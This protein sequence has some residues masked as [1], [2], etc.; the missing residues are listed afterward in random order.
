MRTRLFVFLF[1]I[2]S[3]ILLAQEPVGVGQWRYHIPYKRSVAVE[4]IGDEIF[5]ANRY[6]IFSYEK[7]TGYISYY[8]KRDYLSDVGI[9][10]LEYHE[11]SKSLFIAY[12]S[13]NLDVLKNDKINNFNDIQ[14]SN[15]VSSKKINNVYFKDNEAYLLCPFGIIVFNIDHSEFRETYSIRSDLD[16]DPYD[17]LYDDGVFYVVSDQG[18]FSVL[19]QDLL[20]NSKIEWE[21]V[22]G[23]LP[24]GSYN[25]IHKFH[26][27]IFVNLN[28][29]DDPD[30]MYS[31]NNGTWSKLE[32]FEYFDN[33]KHIDTKLGEMIVTH[34]YGCT[35]H[36]ETFATQGALFEYGEGIGMYTERAKY[37]DEGNVWVADKSLGLGSSL[38]KYILPNGPDNE[39]AFSITASNNRL[40]VATGNRAFSN[41]NNYFHEGMIHIFE[42]EEWKSLNRFDMPE[43]EAVFDILKIVDDP[44]DSKRIYASSLGGGIIEIYDNNFSNLYTD[45]NSSL[46]EED[47][48]N[49]WQYVG[50]SSIDVDASGNLWAVNTRSNRG[51]HVKTPEGEWYGYSIP[52]LSNLLHLRDIKISSSGLKWIQ[53]LDGNNPGLFVYDDNGTVENQADDSKRM[54]VVGEGLGNL[55]SNRV[56]AMEEDHDGHMWVGTTQGLVVF[57]NPQDIINNLQDAQQVTTTSSE[58][59]TE[60]VLDGVGINAI[61]IDGANRKWIGTESNGVY[62]LSADGSEEIYHFDIENSPLLSNYIQSINVHPTSGEVFVSTELGIVSFRGDATEGTNDYDL[63]YVFPNPVK[64]SY[65]GVISITGLINS[66]QVKITDIAGNVVFETT[67]Q[68]GQASWYGRDYSGK[69]VN[70]GVYLIYCYAPDGGSR[71]A[72]KVIL[73]N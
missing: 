16:I 35:T 60:Y 2:T 5:C 44:T 29:K 4:T 7:S 43:L 32:N 31:W 73:I 67:S 70:T 23:N 55:P 6:S 63:A 50:V 8:D 33:N 22:T 36:N 62:L 57:Y 3:S 14:R 66:S 39:R 1:L 48:S 59:Y 61:A 24:Q 10:C 30:T 58:G 12:E 47:P 53:V 34:E 18:V 69:K 51:L 56:F 42:N 19:E 49:N 9:T 15:I 41:G 11:N 21:N 13:G 68:G 54:L 20:N 37:D 46:V 64:E 45:A 25:L 52:E 38:N 40:L 26:N 27:Q 65:N 71:F 17:L 72:G 28:L